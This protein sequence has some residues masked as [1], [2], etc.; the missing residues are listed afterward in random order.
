MLTGWEYEQCLYFRFCFYATIPLQHNLLLPLI[1]TSCSVLCLLGC[2]L[3]MSVCEIKS[4]FWTVFCF[5]VCVIFTILHNVLR[6]LLWWSLN[7]IL[8]ALWSLFLI[9]LFSLS[10]FLLG[11]CW[12]VRRLSPLKPGF[13]FLIS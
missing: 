13:P 2:F 4:H 1:C 9:I 12:A 8:P 7:D 3:F 6:P 5:E 10:L 11:S